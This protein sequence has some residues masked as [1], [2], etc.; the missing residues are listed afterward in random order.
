MKESELLQ[1]YKDYL[2]LKNYRPM[3]IKSYTKSIKFFIQYCKGHKDQNKSVQEFAKSYLVSRF[4]AGISWS[5]V[6]LDY[7]AILILC[8][9]ILHVDWSYTL[10]PRPKSLKKL[11]QILSGKQMQDMINS[12]VN[13]KHKTMILLLYTAGLRANELLNLDKSDICMD[14]HQVHVHLGKRGKDRIVQIPTITIK[15][16]RGYLWQYRPKKYL[17]EGQDKKRRYSTSS[18]RRV[19]L[20]AAKQQ[21]ITNKV[22][23]H[24]LRHSYA[25]HHIINGTD[26]LT[27]QKQLGHTSIKTTLRYIHLCPSRVQQINHPIEKL[28]INI[29]VV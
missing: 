1:S 18:L 22:N 13:L 28:K 19:V 29:P 16:I 23:T 27:L 2:V 14:R 25:T 24:V 17:F 5:S 4:N 6:N 12:V 21:G 26:L 20:M 15:F 10:V 11:P 3:T 8:R 9:H 7:S